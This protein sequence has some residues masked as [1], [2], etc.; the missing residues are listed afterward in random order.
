[1]MTGLGGGRDNAA[2]KRPGWGAKA[3]HFGQ[4][5]PFAGGVSALRSLSADS[6]RC[7]L[8][9]SHPLSAPHHT[10]LFTRLVGRETSEVDW[11]CPDRLLA[12]GDWVRGELDWAR[13]PTAAEIEASGAAKKQRARAKASLHT[14]IDLAGAAVLGTFSGTCLARLD[15]RLFSRPSRDVD[16]P[17]TR[18]Q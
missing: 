7:P 17:R 13:D 15:F 1:M 4:Q 6:Q 2:R 12:S 5:R 14:L 10:A 9:R 18:L 11:V 3:A 16:S 8:T